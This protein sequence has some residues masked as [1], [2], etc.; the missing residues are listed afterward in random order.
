[1]TAF[2]MFRLTIIAFHGEPKTEIAK[3]THDN[4]FVIVLPL[5][6]LA[7]LSFWFIHSPNP[8]D[9][10]QGWFV[11]NLPAPQTAVP[12]KYQFKFLSPLEKHENPYLMA[13]EHQC[14][15]GECKGDC[16][17]EKGMAAA[18]GGMTGGSNTSLYLKTMDRRQGHPSNTPTHNS[19][20]Y[21]L[22]QN[23]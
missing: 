15:E 8:I 17:H 21:Q 14:K 1:M 6:L 18:G 22:F 11:K 2:Y 23:W 13:M 16:E 3:N 4:K 5:V 7:V 20:P 9:A 10:N 12:E 19:S